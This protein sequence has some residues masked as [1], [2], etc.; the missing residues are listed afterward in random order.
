VNVH[1][2]LY[3]GGDWVDPATDAVIDVISPHT[4]EVVGR[5][6]EAATADVDRAVGAAREAFDDGDWP[7]LTPD[8]RIAAVQRFTDA[9]MGRMGDMAE[10]ITTEMGSP[11]TFSHLGQAG[12]AWMMLNTFVQI[13]QQ[14]PWEDTRTGMLGTDVIVRHE[15]LGV[16]AGVV[17]WNVPQFVTIAK[18]APALLTGCTF[19]LKPAPET[20]LDSY[21]MAELLDEAGI[22]KGV[23]SIVPAGREVGEHLV[24]HTGIDKVAFTGS[25]AAGRRIASICGEQLKRVSL[26]LGGKSAAII[27]DDADL[28]ATA[29]GLKMASLMNNGQA[30]VAQTRILASRKRYDEV[31]D[32]VTSMVAGLNVGDPAEDTTEIGPLVAKRQQ[33]RVEKYIALGQEE[34]ARITVGGNG[35]PKGIDRG[36][37]VQPTVFANAT[38]DMRIARE[39]IFGPVVAVIPYDDVRDAVRIANDS[40]YGLAGSV[41]TSDVDQGMEIARRVRTGTYAVNQYTMDFMAPFGGFKSSGIGREFGKEGLEHYV[42]LKT[43]IPPGGGIIAAG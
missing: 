28:A 6:P 29:E 32:A 24:R 5:V 40:D 3:I 25:T 2:K 27:L 4:E 20:P 8:E 18:L 23:V 39:E 37:Y 1:E 30:C 41:W 31:V 33:E 21:L 7:R 43:I 15:P 12:A 17:P 14:F 36:W 9:Y 10:L 13:A 16:V 22:P 35:L 42:E 11:I 19:V 26:E 38:N 34:G